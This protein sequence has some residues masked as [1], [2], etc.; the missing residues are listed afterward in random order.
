MRVIIAGGRDFQ[1]SDQHWKAL[2]RI[3]ATHGI[4][5]VLSGAAR[6]A[7]IFGERW[8]A[9]RRIEIARFPAEWAK[10]GKKAGPMRNEMM[11]EA[12]DALIIF[13]GGKGTRNMVIQA[14][15]YEL[16][17]LKIDQEGNWDT[18]DWR[19]EG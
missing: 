15:R 18:T 5:R 19:A 8:A 9:S 7:D 10:F 16:P 4:D 3:H 14:R 11:A 12:G 6:G 2:D 1:P 13:P 17:I